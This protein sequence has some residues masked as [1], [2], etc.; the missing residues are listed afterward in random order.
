MLALKAPVMVVVK[1]ALIAADTVPVRTQVS[2]SLRT[3]LFAA[4]TASFIAVVKVAASAA[5]GVAP[6]SGTLP[7]H[8]FC[9][10]TFAFCTL[11]CIRF[12]YLCP[13]ICILVSGF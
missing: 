3:A 6:Q 11:R 9:I 2:V 8:P 1:T 7:R 10:L 5:L 4:V 13:P 12:R